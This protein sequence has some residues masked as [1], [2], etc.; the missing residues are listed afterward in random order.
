MLMVMIL[1]SAIGVKSSA[2]ANHVLSARPNV[3]HIENI[4][5]C[6]MV[7]FVAALVI[8]AKSFQILM[9]ACFLL[10]LVDLLL[11]FKQS[12]RVQVS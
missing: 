6:G 9:G 5:W 1:L 10:R 11:C 12:M 8:F 3:S 4:I 2:D 7:L